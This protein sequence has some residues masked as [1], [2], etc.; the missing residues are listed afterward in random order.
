[1][2]SKSFKWQGFETTPLLH[3]SM[4]FKWQGFQN[5]SSTAVFKVSQVAGVP[6]QL[7]YCRIQSHSSGRGFKTTPLLQ[8]S[9]SFKRQGFQNN[10]STAV[11]K[12]IH[13]VGILKQLHYCSIQS[14][15]SCRGSKTTLLLQ[16]SKSFKR[17]GFQNNSATA[18]LKVIQAAGVPKQLR[19]CIIQSHSS[20]G[21]SKT[22]PL[23]QNSKSF[24]RQGFQNNSTTAVFKV[25]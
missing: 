12:V 20:C 3:Y 15:L 17:Q 1:V 4:S 8:Y 25:I 2:D 9:K 19:Y 14:H 18:V 13:A 21:G 23:L 11:F 6:K 24:R 10:N 22:T 16:N 7:C 5:N